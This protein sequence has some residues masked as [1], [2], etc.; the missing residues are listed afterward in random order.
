MI[1][2][3][4][5]TKELPAKEIGIVS[6]NLWSNDVHCKDTARKYSLHKLLNKVLPGRSMKGARKV[7]WDAYFTRKKVYE[8]E[9]VM[10]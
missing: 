4:E 1:Q 9:S 7:F 3:F 5:G 10:H 8:H 6:I 2:H